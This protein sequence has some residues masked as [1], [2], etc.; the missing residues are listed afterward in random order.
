MPAKNSKNFKKLIDEL[1]EAIIR[2]RQNRGEE[3]GTQNNTPQEI[4]Y[5]THAEQKKK[6]LLVSSVSLI[7]V[8]LVGMWFFN[9]KNTIAKLY[10]PENNTDS[11]VS[12]IQNDFSSI[13]GELSLLETEVQAT[14]TPKSD[15]DILKEAVGDI[16]EEIKK[17]PTDTEEKTPT[18]TIEI[19]TQTDI[20]TTTPSLTE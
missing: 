4:S 5:P 11:L 2:E 19:N 14:G 8:V 7:T 1:P 9:F 13:V 18:T 10:S 12:D 15:T 20:T 3:A 16:I 17:Q 6:T